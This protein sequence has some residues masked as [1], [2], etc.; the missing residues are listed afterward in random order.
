MSSIE[1]I[2]CLW[3]RIRFLGIVKFFAKFNTESLM[4]LIKKIKTAIR[5][6]WNVYSWKLSQFLKKTFLILKLPLS[7]LTKTNCSGRFCMENF[8]K[9]LLFSVYVIFTFPIFIVIYVRRRSAFFLVLS[10]NFYKL[11]RFPKCFGTLPWNPN[12]QIFLYWFVKHF[13]KSP[14]AYVPHL[15]ITVDEQ[16]CLFIFLL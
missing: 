13:F 7:S 2:F 9:Y 10:Q 8:Q 14:A 12:V 1:K 4:S 5:R 15:S 16:S 6:V 11:G 3:A